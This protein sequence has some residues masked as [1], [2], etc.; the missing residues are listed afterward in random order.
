MK[1]V[2]EE[3]DGAF[4]SDLI[5]S[6]EELKRLKRGETVDGQAIYKRRKIYVGIRLQGVWDYDEDEEIN[7]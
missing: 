5:A 3:V 1:I 7:E 4:Y 6:P 2:I